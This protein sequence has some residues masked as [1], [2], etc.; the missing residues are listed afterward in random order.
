[1]YKEHTEHWV[2]SPPGP[3]GALCLLFFLY[4]LEL[5]PG[6]F[7]IDTTQLIS[8][9][10]RKSRKPQDTDT[11]SL[12]N[13]EASL[14]CIMS[15]QYGQRLLIATFEEKARSNPEQP[16][17]LLPQSSDL[18]NGFYE[19]KY[20]QMQTAVDY[21]TQWLQNNFGPFSPNET[22]SYMGLT[23]LRYNVF[24]YTAVKLRL[25]VSASV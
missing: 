15:P 25:K 14:I 9:T 4:R 20:K 13:I 2:R 24:F 8:N 17:C 3:F 1:V 7:N 16:F 22:V 10:P 6:F 11:I 5:N 19:V 21:M 18:Q 12:L 23:D